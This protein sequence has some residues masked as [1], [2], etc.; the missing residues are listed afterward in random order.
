M[1]AS[2]RVKR[3]GRIDR[4]T[5]FQDCFGIWNDPTMPVEEIILRYDTL[6]AAFLK[7]FPLHTSQ[8]ILE[9]TAASVTLRVRLRVTNDFVMELLKP[10]S[11]RRRLHE[12]YAEALNRNA[13]DAGNP[14]AATD[15]P[16]AKA[17]T[18]RPKKA[19]PKDDGH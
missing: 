4:E 10:R 8:E 7:T 13:G 3:D 9:E 19:A 11:L 17:A 16:Q 15:R 14:P 1:D 6:D 12:V 18:G 5:L 2:Q